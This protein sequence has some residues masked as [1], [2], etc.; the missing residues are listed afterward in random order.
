ME[1]LDNYNIL[2]LNNLDHSNI[3]N[4]FSKVINFLSE[5]NFKAAQV[6]KLSP[7]KYYRAK[8]DHTN[9]IL[10]TPI[11]NKG[12][13]YLLILDIIRNHDYSKSRFLRGVVPDIENETSETF[14]DNMINTIDEN[15]T[16]LN[17][18]NKLTHVHF[19]DKFISFDDD[20]TIVMN[21]PLPTILIGSAGS[22]K[23]S[24]ML[25]KLKSFEGELL[26]ISLSN[27]LVQHTRQ[28]Y[29]SNNYENEDQEIDFLSFNEFLETIQ[30]NT[31]KEID[32]HNF[33]RWFNQQS[34]PKFINDGRK[35]FEEFRG[36][37]TGN[38]VNAPYLSSEEYLNLG[39]KQSIFLEHERNDVYQL[40]KK[41]LAFLQENNWFDPNLVSYD[42]L[43]LANKKYDT[44]LIDE[45]QDFTN[46]QLTLVL[47]TLKNPQQFFLC[48]DANQIVHPNFFSWSSLKSFFYSKDNPD[49]HSIVRILSRNYRN[50]PEVIEIANRILKL[51]NYKF[52]S[53]DRE[54]HYLMTSTSINRGIVSC[55][56]GK[57]PLIK[58][59]NSKTSRSTKFAILVLH[60]SD[61]AI[62]AQFFGTPLIFTPQEAKGLEYE[63]VI[64]FNFISYEKNFDE[65]AKNV[66]S[67]YIHS[68]FNYARAKDKTDKSLEAY[69][70]Y[71]NSLYVAITRAI[72]NIY[73][74]ED[75]TNN[76]LIRLLDINQ[77]QQI[78]LESNV[79][80][81]EDWAIEASKLA[82]Q[83]KLEQAQAIEQQILQYHKVP[84]EILNKEK[85]LAQ[86]KTLSTEETLPDKKTSILLL[87]YAMIYDDSNMLHILETL[88]L[89]AARNI[90]RAYQ[91]LNEQYFSEYIYKN[92]KSMLDKIKKFGPNFRNQFNFTPLMCASYMLNEI[93]IDELLKQQVNLD[94]L[95]NN[96]RNAFAIMLGKIST[97]EVKIP[98]QKIDNLFRKLCPNSISL[99]IENK[100]VKI[101]ARKTEF[102]IIYFLLLQISKTPCFNFFGQSF[103]CGDILTMFEFFTGSSVV[104]SFKIKRTYLNS[105]LARNEVNSKYPYGLKLFTRIKI[106]QYKLNDSLKFKNEDTW[107]ELT[108]H[109]TSKTLDS[110][111]VITEPFEFN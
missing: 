18:V 11:K 81:I 47:K 49:V 76:R 64:L 85:Y 44:I 42:Y 22:G 29:Y 86:K 111:R 15:A 67:N 38:Q 103:S 104:P 58:E 88:E 105:V 73:L 51:K 28:I 80:S 24:L 9:R 20:Q 52:G 40:F 90:D 39:V 48:G 3:E 102:L 68:E 77:I 34:K 87:N 25:E 107:V 32:I 43:K 109:R 89:K 92:P 33:M 93:C 14:D 71:I 19:L 2:Y 83:G 8:L 94:E 54:T 21:S 72:K 63:N 55:I 106:G 16:E 7:T 31:K 82:K 78:N 74:V 57:S 99:Q 41:Y 53:I 1:N 79:S 59:L 95:D 96:N 101:D 13:K 46:R 45:V 23:T 84:W 91:L 70:F 97:S 4:K 98:L 35:I 100:L 27:Y 69:K 62:A 37:I 108:D 6:K 50:T 75:D 66:D 110:V 17:V 65:I 12:K 61:K 56:D 30:T 60:E 10:F 36:V 26:Y 5:G